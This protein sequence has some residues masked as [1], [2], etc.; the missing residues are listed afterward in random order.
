MSG[1]ADI[2]EKIKHQ[3]P[4]AI[5]FEQNTCDEFP[6]LWVNKENIVGVLGF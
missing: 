3:F 4:D 6:T 1:Y 2:V 5:V